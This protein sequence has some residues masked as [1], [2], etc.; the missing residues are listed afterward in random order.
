MPRLARLASLWVALGSACANMS[1]FQTGRTLG[2]DEVRYGVGSEIS[3]IDE[4]EVITGTDEDE[5]SEVETAFPIP[6]VQG[7]A[8]YGIA[9]NI[10]AGLKLFTVGLAAEMK[11]QFLGDRE[12]PF[13][14]A[15][16]LVFS[17]Y[18]MDVPREEE[19]STGP[20]TL[21][22]Y[23]GLLDVTAA[24]YLSYSLSDD[25]LTIYGSPKYISRTV[26]LGAEVA[27]AAEDAALGLD[28]WGAALG[29]T[30]GRALAFYVEA[31]L[32]RPIGF[33]GLMANVG[34]GVEF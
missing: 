25:W 27:G 12:S 13:A 26:V 9:E 4:F 23:V 32:Y 30:F 7:W 15:T 28:L 20:V 33:D 34:V 11:A 14:A 8:R 17:Y 18:G 22:G 6:A 1:T 21:G 16:G 2:R 24:L 19:D 31:G 29:L 10:D 5:T 3:F